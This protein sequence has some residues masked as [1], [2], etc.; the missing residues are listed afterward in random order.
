MRDADALVSTVDDY[1]TTAIENAIALSPVVDPPVESVEA[2]EEVNTE[3]EVEATTNTTPT[4]IDTTETSDIDTTETS[5][6]YLD[7]GAPSD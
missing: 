5:D 7:D 1:F 3:A 2:E 6:N 4:D